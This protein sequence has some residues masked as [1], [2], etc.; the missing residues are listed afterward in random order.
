VPAGVRGAQRAGEGVV[1][2]HNHV[3]WSI[4]DYTCSQRPAS[5]QLGM[6]LCVWP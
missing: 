4:A 1:L 2:Y 5:A 6:T 3:A